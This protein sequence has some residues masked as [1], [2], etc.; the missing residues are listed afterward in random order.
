MPEEKSPPEIPRPSPRY[1][2]LGK[3]ALA[4]NQTVSRNI[5]SANRVAKPV[6]QKGANVSI[7][8]ISNELF[9]LTKYTFKPKK[10]SI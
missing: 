5:V 9:K 10:I 2:I 1:G 3:D 7:A 6:I 8:R 4:R